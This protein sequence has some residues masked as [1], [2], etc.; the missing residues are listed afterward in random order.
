MYSF[1]ENPLIGAMAFFELFC[2][3]VGRPPGN[4]LYAPLPAGFCE[5]ASSVAAST[6]D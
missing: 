1:A 4:F 3:E 6:I 2:R 5:E